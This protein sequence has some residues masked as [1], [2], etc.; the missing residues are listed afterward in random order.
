[1]TSTTLTPFLLRV[2]QFWDLPT[3]TPPSAFNTWLVRFDNWLAL[4]QL[5]RPAGS[6]LLSPMVQ[7]RSLVK[8]LGKYAFKQFATKFDDQ[9]PVIFDTD[10][11]LLCAVLTT[12]FA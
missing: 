9:L 7:C 4:Q 3:D 12:I 10:Y 5:Q 6:K 2:E 11:G 8:H 1:M